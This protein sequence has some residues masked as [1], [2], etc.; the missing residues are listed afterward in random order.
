LK[1]NDFEKHFFRS[2][3]IKSQNMYNAILIDELSKELWRISNFFD[4]TD[5][6]IDDKHKKE[7]IEEKFRRLNY[8]IDELTTLTG[9][10]PGPWISL[11]NGKHFNNEVKKGAQIFLD[12]LKSYFMSQWREGNLIEK[13][14]TD[15]IL[16]AKGPEEFS[17]LRD[18]YQNERL[19]FLVLDQDNLQKTAY[20]REKIVQKM[21]PGFMK[22]TSGTGRA[23]FY[24][25]SKILGKKEIDTYIF[26][27]SSIW[28][29]T[30]LLYGA[31]YFKLLH[32]FIKN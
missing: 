3:I 20:T 26:N 25:P 2:H 7:I 9:I 23:H 27:L 5:V 8:H 30:F 31:L 17:R 22:T 19:E 29:V 15:S 14:V 11:L 16:R 4:S 18:K 32:K 24:A 13:T 28:L 10:P 21:D 12:S 6:L 1:D